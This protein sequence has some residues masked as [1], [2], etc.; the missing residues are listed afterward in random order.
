MKLGKKKILAQKRAWRVRS[1]VSGTAERPRL[2]LRFSNKHIATQCIDD[3]VGKT[4]VSLSSLDKELKADNVLAN[5]A[6][7][8][9]LGKKLGEKIKAAGISAVVL[10]R[11]SRRYA[12][13]VKSFADA[14]R[15]TGINF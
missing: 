9:L 13:C 3:V 8:V 14:V 11:G 5:N 4:L 2:V 1:R 10:D 15:E 7:A 6:G 12:G